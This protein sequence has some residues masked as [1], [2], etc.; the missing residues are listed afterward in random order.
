VR[1]GLSISAKVN[2]VWKSF[3]ALTRDA[4]E[5]FNAEAVVP[6][7]RRRAIAEGLIVRGHSA[8]SACRITG[9][10]RSLLQYYRRRPVPGRQIGR[11]IVADTISEIHQRS[12]GTY[13]RRRMRAALLAGYDMNV[14]LKLVNSIMTDRY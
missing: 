9:L 12:R 10:A 13:G 2:A 4:C 14:N 1:K 8:R 7:K 3:L 5:L 6:P 11:P